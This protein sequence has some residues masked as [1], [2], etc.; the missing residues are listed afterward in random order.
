VE[1]VPAVRR[2]LLDVDA[3]RGYVGAKVFKNMLHEHVDGTGGRAVVVRREG[4]WRE[5]SA[6]NT[7]RFPVLAVDCW[8]DNTRVDGLVSKQDALDSAWA[9]YNVVDVALALKRNVFWG[10]Y[11]LHPGLF[12]IESRPWQEP[13]EQTRTESHQGSFQ[14]VALGECAVVTARYALV[15]G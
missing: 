2:Q 1:V 4:G 7:C 11:G 12:V 8:A 9:V 14:G 15:T 10:G 3:V 6:T 5:M 13:L